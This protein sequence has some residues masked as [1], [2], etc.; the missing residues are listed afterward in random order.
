MAAEQDSLVVDVH[1]QVKRPVNVGPTDQQEEDTVDLVNKLF[2]QAKKYRENIGCEK[3]WQENY[4][5]FVGKQWS[6]R[7]PRYRAS[8][9]INICWATIQT[10]VPIVTDNRPQVSYL[11][12]E[13]T[14]QIFT[15]TLNELNEYNWN[16]YNWNN[17]LTDGVIDSCIYDAAHF[18]V[19]WNP[20]LQKGIGDIEFKVL[21]PFYCYP[22]PVAEDVNSTNSRF[23]IYAEPV[24]VGELKRQYP[25]KD[26][27][28]DL[29]TLYSQKTRDVEQP[30]TYRSP[31]NQSYNAGRPGSGTSQRYVS[32]MVLKIHCWMKDDTTE[33][34]E[35]ETE[36]NGEKQY[37]TKLKFPKGRYVVVANNKVLID[38]ANPYEDGKFPFVRLVNYS[39][40]REYWGMGEIDQLKGLQRLL[41]STVSSIADTMKM[42]SNPVW[43]VGSAANMDT[44]NIT[45]EP[46]LIMEA[47]DINQVRR[48]GGEQLPPY[49]MQ[50]VETIR[51]LTDLVSGVHDSSRGATQPGVT[52]GLML[53]GFIEAAQTRIRL[54]NRN[55]DKAIHEIGWLMLSRIMQ[56]YTSPRIYRI[57]NKQQQF[58]FNQFYMSKEEGRPV[59]NISQGINSPV[60]M[61]QNTIPIKGFPDVKVSSGSSLP[62]MKAQKAAVALQLFQTGSIDQEELLKA[63]NW[64][65]WENVLQRVQKQAAMAAQQQGGANA[66]KK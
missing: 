51:S 27:H 23:F 34:I 28:G 13:P 40:P 5:F 59:A 47:G 7:R 15:D 36:L 46:G 3:R 49:L 61:Q 43:L 20:E 53:E 54:K 50:M 30:I 8:E 62:Y 32:D 1:A 16:C 24:T 4:D 38:V 44:E 66:V 19:T 17:T 9:V 56:F 29:G 57:T 31:D 33:E 10:V 60:T 58:T 26:I 37:A 55:L 11:P 42:S 48:V 63:N 52:S 64:P 45:N 2:G 65:D 21:D 22:D 39:L 12:T 18:S 6:N 25:D 41:N 35:M 14:D